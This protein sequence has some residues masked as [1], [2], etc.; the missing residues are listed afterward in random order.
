M[1]S[2][3]GRPF[4]PY[5]SQPFYAIDADG[6]CSCQ[7]KCNPQCLIGDLK[8]RIYRILMRQP[9]IG[10]R[11]PEPW[12]GFQAIIEELCQRGVVHANASDLSEK[13]FDEMPALDAGLDRSKVFRALLTFYHELGLVYYWGSDVSSSKEKTLTD[14]DHLLLN[15]VIINMKSFIKIMHDLYSHPNQ[16][17]RP[18]KPHSLQ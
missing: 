18:K 2:I 17:V 15:T 14:D 16:Q 12:I 6:E 5:I 1:Q 4:E 8:K 3:K 13:V 9:L 10:Q 7:T 11:L